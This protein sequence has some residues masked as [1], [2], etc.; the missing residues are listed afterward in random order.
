MNW[1]FLWPLTAFFLLS[2][3]RILLKS[4]R[5]FIRTLLGIAIGEIALFT[6][7]LIGKLLGFSL[8]LSVFSVSVAGVLGVPGVTAML[9][10]NLIL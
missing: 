9:L 1:A 6:V 10:L 5:P 8:P 3:I 7:H 2:V 4:R